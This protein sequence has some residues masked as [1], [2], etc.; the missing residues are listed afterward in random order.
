MEAAGLLHER[1]LAI[2]GPVWLMANV[3]R[4]WDDPERRAIVLEAL[5]WIEEEPSLLGAG[6]HLLAVARKA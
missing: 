2:E 5:R 4:D 3:V 1:T 6:G